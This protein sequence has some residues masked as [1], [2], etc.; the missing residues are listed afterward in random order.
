[1]LLIRALSKI[2]QDPYSAFIWKYSAS[3]W[4]VILHLILKRVE[5]RR[6]G[7]ERIW[8]HLSH[9]NQIAWDLKK[10]F[11][12][13]FLFNEKYPELAPRSSFYN[14]VLN[15]R[16]TLLSSQTPAHPIHVLTGSEHRSNFMSRCLLL[17]CL[18]FRHEANVWGYVF[19]P[20]LLAK[21]TLNVVS[22]SQ[23]NRAGNSFIK[24][25]RFALGTVP[26]H[27]VLF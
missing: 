10:N 25:T 12:G 6:A 14:C 20:C 5:N 27:S 7:G 23:R 1:M 3:K 16:S 22:G 24:L 21:A 17:N 15:V 9:R 26:Q 8:A 19:H 18:F 2:L 4:E 13:C 11:Y